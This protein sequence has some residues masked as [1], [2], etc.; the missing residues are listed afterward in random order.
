MNKKTMLEKKL[1]KCSVRKTLDKNLD[2]WSQCKKF[3]VV[4]QK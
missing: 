3:G 1:G 2:Y 4:G